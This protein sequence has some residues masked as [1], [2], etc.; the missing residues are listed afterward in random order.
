PTTTSTCRCCARSATGSP[1]APVNTVTRTWPRPT[2]RALRR[3]GDPWGSAVSGLDPARAAEDV[4]DHRAFRLGVVVHV[5]PLAPGEL[6]L[7]GRIAVAV[8]GVGAQVIA[9]YQVPARL[10]VVGRVAVQVHRLVRIACP[11]RA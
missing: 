10:D 8:V 6:A 11:Q 2:C 1:R 9:Q 7:G 4:P 3:R 5:V